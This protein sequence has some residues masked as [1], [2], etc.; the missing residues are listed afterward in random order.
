MNIYEGWQRNPATD[1]PELH[2]GVEFADGSSHVISQMV[3]FTTPT[4][5]EV[6]VDRQRAY[7]LK[8]IDGWETEPEEANIE[9]WA[10]D[11]IQAWRLG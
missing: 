7:D 11:K 9:K 10:A 2:G 4:G 3:G 1:V 8:L 5:A 6:Q